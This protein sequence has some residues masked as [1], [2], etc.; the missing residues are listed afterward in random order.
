MYRPRY[1]GSPFLVDK[2]EPEDDFHTYLNSVLRYITSLAGKSELEIGFH[3]HF[4]PVRAATAPSPPQL[5]PGSSGVY[6]AALLS[7]HDLPI[8]ARL[9][10]SVN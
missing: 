2:S 4:D 9:H 8:L 10:G 5:Q 1:V 3:R 6:S 7:H